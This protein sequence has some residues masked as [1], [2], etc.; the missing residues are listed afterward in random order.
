MGW[1][2]W[3]V[4]LVAVVGCGQSEQTASAPP[5]ETP[6]QTAVT[7]RLALPFDQACVTSAPTDS[8]PPPE[9][10]LTGKPTA[11]LQQAVRAAWGQVTFTETA[12]KPDPVRVVLNTDAGEIELTLFPDLAPN[13]VRNF[14]ALAKV[15]Y[16][17][18]LVFE[19]VVKQ[20]AVSTDGT[21]VAVEFVTAG[22]PAGDGTPGRGHLGYFLK[23]EFNDLTHGEGTVGF[24]R[25]EDDASA[26][27]RFYITL[28]K[29]PVMDGKYTAIGKVTRGLPAVERIAAAKTRDG[30]AERPETA[31][32]IRSVNR[33]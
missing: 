6:P 15:G 19:R 27:T 16:Y 3:A 2:T 12:G 4:G 10:T 5:S 33:D 8:L 26:G 14:L 29:C 13:H 7:T 18:G 30:E 20:Q 9:K 22:C 25:E 31:T 24:L 21:T 32:V 11:P 17:D 28:G 23:P 1:R